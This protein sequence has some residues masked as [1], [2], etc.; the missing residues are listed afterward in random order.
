MVCFGLLLWWIMWREDF[1]GM[2]TQ[3]HM[4]R[5]P[6]LTADEFYNQFYANSDISQSTINRLL[7]ITAE[8]FG[9]HRGQIRPDDNF[10]Q[11]TLGDTIYYV[12]EISE[13]F[14]IPDQIVDNGEI[15]GTFDEIARWVTRRMNCAA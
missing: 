15:D 6:K 13:E 3:S 1:D 5:R 12:T 10:L 7:E 11:T 8:Q 2:R 14:G 9:V 4:E